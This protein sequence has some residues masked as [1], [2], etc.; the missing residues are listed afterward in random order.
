MVES[1]LEPVSC[2]VEADAGR[3]EQH[4]HTD[5]LRAGG[6]LDRQPGV[7]RFFFQ[8]EDGIRDGSVTGVQTC[9]LPISRLCRFCRAKYQAPNA[10]G[11]AP[12]ASHNTCGQSWGNI[13]R[14]TRTAPPNTSKNPA[15]HSAARCRN[16]DRKSVV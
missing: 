15:N 12:P 5:Q 4:I 14:V 13:S 7:H 1:E 2:P 3:D 9:A 10:A 16:S 6:V 11:T 8:A